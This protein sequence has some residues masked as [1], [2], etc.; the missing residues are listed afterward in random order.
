MI[1]KTLETKK[2]ASL[3]VWARI[4]LIIISYLILTS[5]F[6]IIGMLIANISITDLEDLA[7]LN[8]T[9]L[10]IVQFLG[11][12]ALIIVV[13]IFR[14][15]IDKKSIKSL[16]FSLVNRSTD[17]I[18]GFIIA[19]SIIGGGSL[20]L[21]VLG[22]IDFTNIQFDFQ[23]LLL[24]FILFIIISLNEEI[25]IRGYILNNLLTVMNKYYAL[26]ISAIIFT[27]FHSFNFDLSLFGITN[28]FLAGILLGTSYI[29]TKNLWFPIS[30][31]LFWNFF[32]GPV[33]GYSVSGQKIDSLLTLKTIGNETINGGEFGFEG[34]ILCTMFTI[35]SIMMIL[36]FYSKKSPLT[37]PVLKQNI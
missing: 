15:F 9:Q 17:I 19:L 13:Y 8:V 36:I 23:S 1:E 10:L 21:Y 4:V 14:K 37:N 20:I 24:S 27:L 32:Q 2:K 22:Y 12:I 29:F 25:L 6:Q 33:F 31:H 34:S 7:N 35:V 30:L 5:V 18:A 26:I 3:P 11:L 16:G 28:I